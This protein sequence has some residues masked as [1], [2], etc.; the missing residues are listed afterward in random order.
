MNKDTY[1]KI[2]NKLKKEYHI[3]LVW[4]MLLADPNQ[5]VLIANRKASDHILLEIVS[6]QL[7]TIGFKNKNSIYLSEILQAFDH[8]NKYGKINGKKE[9]YEGIYQ[10]I[11]D[12]TKPTEVSFPILIGKTRKWLRLNIF[13]SPK[14]SHLS[15]FV[16]KDITKLHTRE[17]DIFYK[18]HI[19]SL[20]NLYNKY[21]FDHHYGRVYKKE[22]F[23][24][25]FMDI[26]N[27]KEVNDQYGHIVGNQ[28]LNAFAKLLKSLENRDN[29][30]Y[31]LG[32]DEFVGL[33]VGTDQEIKD[34]AERILKG[35]QE[36]KVG[37][38]DVTLTVSMG[39]M[40]A[41]Q[42]IDLAKKADDLMYKVKRSGKNNYRYVVESS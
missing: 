29:Y 40:K 1:E 39:V 15:L 34:M 21:T 17:E 16:F 32:G 18:T 9:Y 38:S 35:I 31:R 23:H 5:V 19:D 33:L 26:D 42:S 36:I 28:Y 27:F 8:N 13:N 30:F 3:D 22:G 25:M 11:Y 4:D 37:R 14:A 12:F 24:V 7:E 2:S 41:T 6:G 20:T 10:Q